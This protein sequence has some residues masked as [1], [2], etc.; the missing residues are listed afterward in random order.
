M[1]VTIFT[2]DCSSGYHLLDS[3]TKDISHDDLFP[4]TQGMAQFVEVADLSLIPLKLPHR[5]GHSV[6]VLWTDEDQ[7]S[8][9]R[10]PTVTT[11]AASS[12]FLFWLLAAQ[13]VTNDHVVEHWNRTRH[14]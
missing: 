9:A 7:A 5:D 3:G 6:Q 13:T 1:S 11:P 14:A 8:E 4:L 12:L 10:P 2:Q